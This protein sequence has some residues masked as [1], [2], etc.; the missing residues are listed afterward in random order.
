M[1]SPG[2]LLECS[3][4]SLVLFQAIGASP[5]ISLDKSLFFWV[6]WFPLNQLRLVTCYCGLKKSPSAINNSRSL[7][8]EAGPMP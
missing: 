1:L 7:G 6:P 5:T 3:A 2:V 4:K 8:I